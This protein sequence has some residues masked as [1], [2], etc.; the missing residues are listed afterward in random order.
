MKGLEMARTVR[1]NHVGWVMMRHLRFFL[2]LQEAFRHSTGCDVFNMSFSSIVSKS[3]IPFFSTFYFSTSLVSQSWHY[4]HTPP[5]W[6]NCSDCVC[7]TSCQSSGSISLASWC[8]ASSCEESLRS[9]KR[10][11]NLLP[12]EAPG[13]SQRT[14]RQS[15]QAQVWLSL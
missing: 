7:L 12:P 15:R 2:S 11:C 14:W 6:L 5:C 1:M 3:W 10:S 9:G 13:C 4:S 8:R